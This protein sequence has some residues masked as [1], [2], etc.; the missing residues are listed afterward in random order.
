VSPWSEG[1]GA[2]PPKAEALLVFRRSIEAANLPTFLKFRNAKNSNICVIFAK[3]SCAS[4]KLGGLE[5]N[6]GP[7]PPAR[8]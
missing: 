3:K 7:V 4:M 1:Q 8:A 6:W 5:Q 2:K